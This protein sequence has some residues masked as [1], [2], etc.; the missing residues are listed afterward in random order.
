MGCIGF[1]SVGGAGMTCGA[2]SGVGIEMW[3]GVIFC[4]ILTPSERSDVVVGVLV[5]DDVA[6]LGMSLYEVTCSTTGTIGLS[7]GIG[8]PDTTAMKVVK[9]ATSDEKKLPISYL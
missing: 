9:M 8:E 6:T 3:A 5:D 2:G 1:G 7:T 4:S